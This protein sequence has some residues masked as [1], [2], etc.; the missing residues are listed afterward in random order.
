LGAGASGCKPG[1]YG[2]ECQ[3]AH[4]LEGL[5]VPVVGPIISL[6]MCGNEGWCQPLLIADAALQVVGLYM[7]I[8]GLVARPYLVREETSMGLPKI[9]V[10]AA[11]LPGGSIVAVSG[12]F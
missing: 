2:D 4:Q 9:S 12:I 10:S 5:A 11:P 3:F 6:E 1:K 8:D 7:L